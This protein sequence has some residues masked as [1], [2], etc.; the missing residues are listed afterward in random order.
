M[1][2]YKCQDFYNSHTSISRTN[3]LFLDHADNQHVFIRCPNGKV[4]A[5]KKTTLCWFFRDPTIKISSDRLRRFISENVHTKIQHVRTRPEDFFICDDI[6]VGEWCYFAN[7]LVGHVISFQYIKGTKRE[8]EYSLDFAPIEPPTRTELK[9]INVM[10]NWYSVDITKLNT[11]IYGSLEISYINI[12]KYVCH[13]NAPQ[14]CEDGLHISEDL[15]DRIK[16]S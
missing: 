9:G 16:K 2:K 8:K 5:V 7:S 12:D 15:I 6:C 11:V 10:C 1:Y 4:I 13:I 3:I 14:I